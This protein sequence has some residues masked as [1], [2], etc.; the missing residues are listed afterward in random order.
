MV[1]SPFKSPELPSLFSL[2]AGSASG[3]A[4]R[5]ILKVVPMPGS[6]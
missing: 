4:G 6:L 5:Y 1:S 3:A 2:S